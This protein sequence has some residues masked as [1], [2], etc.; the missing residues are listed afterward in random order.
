[1]LG[2]GLGHIRRQALMA[3]I[4]APHDPLKLR[5]LPHQTAGQIRLGEAPRQSRRFRI[6][7]DTARDQ[8]RR[9]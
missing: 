4:I 1:M 5:K 9:G 3:R 2:Y 6:G 8:A 7:A